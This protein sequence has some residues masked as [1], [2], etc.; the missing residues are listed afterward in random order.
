MITVTHEG[1]AEPSRQYK[2]IISLKETAGAKIA[3]LGTGADS[4][5]AIGFGYSP[6]GAIN[7]AYR[8]L[9]EYIYGL[10]VTEPGE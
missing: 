4:P 1:D 3:P 9:G 6:V 7:D 8:S 2:A 5:H 10:K